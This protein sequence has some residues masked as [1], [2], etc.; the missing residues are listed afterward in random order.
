M[1]LRRRRR[2][3]SGDV[4]V[5]DGDERRSERRHAPGPGPVKAGPNWH[6]VEDAFGDVGTGGSPRDQR[7]RPGPHLPGRHAHHPP[8]R[9]RRHHHP[10]PSPAAEDRP[11]RRSASSAAFRRR[12][13]RPCDS[14]ERQNQDSIRLVQAPSLAA[15]EADLRSGKIDLAIVDGD[16][17]PAQPARRRSNSSPADPGLVQDVA[18]YLGV[19]KAYQAAGLTP[20]QAAQVSQ[21]KPVPVQTLEPGAKS[22][23]QTDVG[24]R[25]GAVVLH[26]HAVQHLDPHR[27]HAGEV[28]PGRRGP[29]GDAAPHPAPGRQGAGHRARGPGPG[30]PHR[31]LRPDPRA[32]AV[33]SDLL[34]GT[35]PLVLAVPAALAGARVRL[36]LLGL[37]R[38]RLDGRAPGPGADA[39]PP[40]QHPDPGRATS[41]RSRWR[42][43]ATRTSSSRSSPT[44]PRRRR[45]ACR[46]SS[47]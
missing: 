43:R 3:R 7:A 34:H 23:T 10:D 17:D 11:P 13:S 35:A 24:D 16:A 33:G 27:R 29:A 5:C 30:H 20:A 32:A 21:A 2:R 31:R 41:S 39:R 40:A 12:P 22:T 46:C 14:R 42:A 4:D 18:E 1:V 26:A 6:A 38:R 9:R 8:R 37:R 44:C 45:S 36:L 15:A 47:G 28:E 25:A 19:L